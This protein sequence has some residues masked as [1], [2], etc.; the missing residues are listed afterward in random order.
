MRLRS[1]LSCQARVVCRGTALGSIDEVLK[2]VVAMEE[3]VADP[4][5][6]PVENW[7]KVLILDVS[8]NWKTVVRYF[9]LK[10][11]KT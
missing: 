11:F 5:K 8:D 1:G 3:M 9:F 7:S 2:N 6:P 4:P 10:A